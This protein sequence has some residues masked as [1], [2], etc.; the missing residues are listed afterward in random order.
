MTNQAV[1]GGFPFNWRILPAWIELAGNPQAQVLPSCFLYVQDI[2]WSADIAMEHCQLNAHHPG[3]PQDVQGQSAASGALEW[4]MY[5]WA[6]Y[7]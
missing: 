6:L 4:L 3:S 7:E 1:A 2:T 5:L